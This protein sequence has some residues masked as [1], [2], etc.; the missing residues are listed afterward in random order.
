V[1]NLEA[2]SASHQGEDGEANMLQEAHGMIDHRLALLSIFAV[3]FGLLVEE[4]MLSAIFHVLLGAGNTVA[5]I[6]IALVGLSA[7]GLFAY[8]APG[9]QRAEESGELIVKLLFWFAVSVMGSAYLIMAIPIHHGDLIYHRDDIAVQ[10]WRLVVYHVTVAPF[11]IGGLT[12]AT[13]LR[14]DP[15]RVGRLYFADL[16]GAALG[17]VISPWLLQSVGAPAAVIVAAVPVAAVAVVAIVRTGGG[18]RRL[19]WLPIVLCVVAPLFPELLSFRI[20]NTMGEVRDAE[21]RSFRISPGD[22]AFERWAL[23]AWTIIRSDTIPEQWEHFDGWGLSDRYQGDVPSIAF[24]NY[25]ARFSTYVTA[26]GDD[27]SALAAWVDADLGSLHHL[28]GRRFARVLNIG[29]GG[30]REVLS[31]LQHGAEKVIAVDVSEVVVEEIMKGELLEFSGGLYADPRVEAIADEGRTFS[32][33]RRDHFDLIEFSIVGGMNLEKMDLVRVDDLFTVEAIRTYLDRLTD[34][35][36]F[37]YGMYSTRSDLV[38]ERVG[39]SGPPTQPY[40]PSLRTLAGVRLGLEAKH[41]GLN[42]LDHV[43]IAALPGRVDPKYDLVHIIASPRAFS[44]DEVRRFLT[45]ASALDFKVLYPTPGDSAEPDLYRAILEEPDLVALSRRLPFS[46]LPATDDR[47]F[48]YAL[49]ATHL[50]AAVTEGHLGAVLAGNPLISL[51]LSIGTLAFVLTL[52]PLVVTLRQ[53]GGVALIRSS[54]SL[55]VYF[56]CI[57]FAYMAVEIAALLRLQSYLGKPIYGLSVGLFAFL[58]SSGLGSAFSG[59]IQLAG[60]ERAV[61]AAVGGIVVIGGVFAATSGTLFEATIALPLAARIAIAITAIFPLAFAMGLLFPLGVRLI[62]RENPDLIPWA[63]AINGCFS[64]L[65]IFGTR[66][67]A[68][69]L[70]FSRSL[71]LGLIAYA[72]VMGCVYLAASSRS[73]SARP[74]SSA[75]SVARD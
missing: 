64:V 9:F 18:L 69:F 28:L 40:I 68:L 13:I 37:S 34:D 55:L 6:A 44:A 46:T 50:L 38:S 10:L 54:W 60:L 23:D 39:A 31:A 63:W 26:P 74:S 57:G 48:Q 73:R 58:F 52:I 56:A 1:W 41:P 51:G 33:R 19:A 65:G 5:A 66:I 67:T 4:I 22:I 61:Y 49:D 25:N 72:L 71:V 53:S 29:A 24:V 42:V 12:I 36:V 11:F 20:L 15:Q 14:S 62:A 16:F 17:C 59:R 70:G 3:S 7:S 43:L 75:A 32:E 21:Y 8:V 45:Q 47:P 27:P 35:G 2:A 30:G